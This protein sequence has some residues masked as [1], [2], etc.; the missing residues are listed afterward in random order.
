MYADEC[1]LAWQNC[2]NWKLSDEQK[3]VKKLQGVFPNACYFA[4]NGC[5]PLENSFG[6]LLAKHGS[7]DVLLAVGEDAR[8][9][10]FVSN[11]WMKTHSRVAKSWMDKETFKSLPRLSRNEFLFL[12]PN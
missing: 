3:Y 5:F 10:A 6:P 7:G 1:F 12:T 4:K 8:N 11:G 9:Y 2:T